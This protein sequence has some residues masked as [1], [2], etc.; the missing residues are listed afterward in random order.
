[1]HC[2]TVESAKRERKNGPVGIGGATGS[3]N[4]HLR[5]ELGPI[6]FTAKKALLGDALLTGNLAI[7]ESGLS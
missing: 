5:R 3:A 7:C 6:L 2:V 4:I 1:M